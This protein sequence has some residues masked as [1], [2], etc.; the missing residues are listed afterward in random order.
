MQVKSYSIEDLSILSGFTHR[1]IRYYIQQRLLEPPAGRG[2][3]GFYYDSHLD[4]LLQ[5]KSLQEKGHTLA[6]ITQLLKTQRT[7]TVNYPRDIW[8]RYEII[9]GLE[10]SARRNIDQ[11]NSGKLFEIIKFARAILPQKEANE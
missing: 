6:A 5:I 9:P 8:V 1:T 11:Q 3:G 4:R 10:I 2:R 7:P